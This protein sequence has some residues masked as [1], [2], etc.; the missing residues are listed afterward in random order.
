MG[1]RTGP[2][3]DGLFVVAYTKNVAVHRSQLPQHTILHGAQ[4]LKFVD[5]EIV[6]PG[7][8]LVSGCRI[9]PQ[10]LLRQHDEIVEVHQVVCPKALLIAGEELDSALAQRATLQAVQAEQREH[11]GPELLRHPKALQQALLIVWVRNAKAGLE[12]TAACVV[13]QDLETDGVQRSPGD[14]IPA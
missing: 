10:Q 5:Q 12:S 7:A 11:P 8:E 2:G 3:K 1:I 13:A 6:P 4:I 14:I 9:G